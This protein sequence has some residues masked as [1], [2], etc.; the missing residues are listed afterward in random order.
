MKHICWTLQVRPDKLEEYKE[1][2]KH[3]WPEMQQALR[4]TGWHNY[5]LFLRDDGTLIGYLETEDF[6]AALDG[7]AKREVNARWQVVAAPL[8]AKLAGKKADESMVTIEEVFHL[9]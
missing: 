4:E 5:S 8:F 2:H 6:Q 7:M 1:L 9:D 3:V